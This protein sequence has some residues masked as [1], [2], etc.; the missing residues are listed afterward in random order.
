MEGGWWTFFKWLDLIWISPALFS[1]WFSALRPEHQSPI[2]DVRFW[3]PFPIQVDLY[4]GG[5]PFRPTTRFQR[6]MWK[7]NNLKW[8]SRGIR[9]RLRWKWVR[10]RFRPLHSLQLMRSYVH[11]RLATFRASGRPPDERCPSSEHDATSVCRDSPM[12]TQDMYDPEVDPVD[13]LLSTIHPLDLFRNEMDIRTKLF[14][15]S[16]EAISMEE[17]FVAAVDLERE[18]KMISKRRAKTKK[19][20]LAKDMSGAYLT[21]HQC[22]C[23]MP[24]VFDTG[25]SYSVTPNLQ[26]FVG[27]LSPTDMD[28]MKGLTD[29]VK[30]KGKGWVEWSVRDVFGRVH[31]IRTKA[32]HVPEASIRLFSPQSYFQEHD[33]GRGTFDKSS[34]TFTTCDG[35]D[36]QF[37]YHPGSNLPF[38][39]L[40]EGIIQAGLT[41]RDLAF[42]Q[43][44]EN[45]ESFTKTFHDNNHNLSKPQKELL[46]WHS[47]LGHA[48]F[49]WIQDLMR[50][51][52]PQVVGEISDPPLIP[53][54]ISGTANCSI[55]LCPACQFAKA[56]R[57]TPDSQKTT[58]VREHDMA[59]RKNDLNPGDCVSIDQY[60]CKVPG[61]PRY[62]YGKGKAETKYN[63][64]TIFVDHA[65]GY[66]A[67][68]HQ[69][70]L[71]TGETLQKKHLFERH[72]EAN[73]AKV[74][75]YRADNHPFESAGFLQDLETQNQTITYSGMGAHHQNGVAERALQ[76]VTRWALAMMMHQLVHW[77][78]EFDPSL[79]PFALEHAVHIWNNMPKETGGL[80]PNELFA[81]IKL[82]QN[83]A[84][85]RSRVWG[86]P[87]YVLDPKLQDGKKLPKW[88]PR[89]RLG[90]YLGISPGHSTTV[91]R[92]LNIDTGYVLP[93]Y[94]L[95]FDELYH[96]VNGELSD[97]SFDADLWNTLLTLQGL[98]KADDRTD[99]TGD[100]IPFDDNFEEF[101]QS[102]P[103]P[104]PGPLI[105][106]PEGD[107]DS[108]SDSVGTSIPEGDKDNEGD[109][110]E[111][112]I[113][114][115]GRRVIKPTPLH[116]ANYAGHV[117]KQ[118]NATKQPAYK[119]LQYL[120]GGN[121]R[122]KVRQS[123][124]D[125]Q[126]M[127]S[128]NWNEAVSQLKTGHG[129]RTMLDVYKDYD[130]ESGTQETWNPLAMAA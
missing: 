55:P 26:D 21:E 116:T 9:L 18:L 11:R 10:L 41:A 16:S 77:P 28:S 107:E 91:G 105:S 13:K 62:G 52:K 128:L 86:C 29:S 20:Q 53:T 32:F 46:L 123:Q 85:L 33:R 1:L 74:K 56:H 76:T 68:H 73:G 108:D 113:T 72:A 15:L 118:T 130:F 115:S 83:D 126:H 40:D 61:R 64:G 48:G 66:V 112:Y 127:A 44:A 79:W 94:H 121:P 102:D 65:S 89:S 30:I 129:R 3:F 75:G 7:K 27:E 50:V 60:I 70:S 42:L 124:L 51:Q 2:R 82:P 92:V 19:K 45:I 17:A 90:M 14:G 84:I 106:V 63:G 98:E 57:R 5:L 67:V 122:A 47:R 110:G 58:N 69:I 78:A 103:D 37:P 80:T 71:G 38:M 59:I 95:V 39:Y 35:V 111:P 99:V 100:E 24:I 34:L 101:N 109:I 125:K 49:R 12:T 120:A 36:L 114:R 93:Q 8:R 43:E 54:K 119:N 22:K 87:V 25:A 31:M 23:D 4:Y 117:P 6:Y 96:T 88:K 104:D 81:G 97:E